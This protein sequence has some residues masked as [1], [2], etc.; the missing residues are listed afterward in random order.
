MYPQAKPFPCRPQLHEE[1]PEPL[2]GLAWQPLCPTVFTVS[3]AF[4]SQELDWLVFLLEN[5]EILT[6]C[7]GVT[8]TRSV[9]AETLSHFMVQS[10][11]CRPG[12]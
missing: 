9:H 3:S 12:F 10:M 4:S 8:G 7:P 11:V 5:L 6:Q 1:D 2:S